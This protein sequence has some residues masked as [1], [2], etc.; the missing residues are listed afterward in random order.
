MLE[1]KWWTL[2]AICVAT[3][4]LLIDVTIVVVALPDIQRDLGA[5]FDEVQWVVDAYALTLASFLLT[6]GSLADRF[7][8]RLVF[9]AGLGAF[10]LASLACS[11]A[12]DATF[13]DI[14]RGV[15]GIGGAAMFATSLSLLA[16]AFTGRERGTA[17]GVWGAT[18]G[19]AVAIGPLVGGALTEGLSWEWIFWINLPIGIGAIALTLLR[20]E[21]SRDPTGVRFDVL[22]FL[23]FTGGL[24]ALV[25]ALIRGNDLGWGSTTIVALFAASA[26]LLLA[27]VAVE[28]RYRDPMF[29]LSLF[30]KPAFGGAA[31]AALGLHIAMFSM[32]LYMVLYVQNVLG[33]SPLEAGL[34]FLPI[35]MLSFFA[36]PVAG[37]LSTRFPVRAFLGG[38][39]VLIGIG[40]LLMGGIDP[41]DDW[42]TLLAG[43]IVAGIGIGTVNPPL[44][45]TAIGVVKPPQ[46]GMASGINNTFRQVG[47]ATGIAGFG[48]ILQ[49]RVEAKLSDMLAST[50]AAGVAERLGD[51][52]ASGQVGAVAGAAPPQAREAV[53]R[54]ARESFISGLNE[55]FV[56]AAAV[57]FVAAVLAFALTRSRD[58]EVGTAQEERAAQ[59]AAA[60]AQAEP[61]TA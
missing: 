26:L 42:E 51:A 36:A 15:Q 58:F 56:V 12:P 60:G 21:E 1:R 6:T 43:F 49:G 13:L 55:L 48:A 10:T 53:A 31:I 54:A 34:I 4:M 11:L 47:I 24:G 35:S 27:F 14:A 59:A 20:V 16:Q 23:T 41:S 52:V 40:L 22:G 29:D 37:K 5:S 39:L 3:F 28:R 61:Q 38:G 30:R 50:P 44:A 17:F 25:L 18:T 46:S 33:Y 57:A 7:G 9:V 19:A 32:F 8:R 2:I 45:S